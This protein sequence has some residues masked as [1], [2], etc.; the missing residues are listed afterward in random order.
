MNN[1]CNILGKTLRVSSISIQ[2]RKQTLA[3][4]LSVLVG[5][6]Q[7]ISIDSEKSQ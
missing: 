2:N 1:E 3:I 5:F 7:W 4:E 6:C